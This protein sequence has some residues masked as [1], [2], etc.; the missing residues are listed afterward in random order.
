MKNLKKGRIPYMAK[1]VIEAF[2]ILAPILMISQRFVGV[3]LSQYSTGLAIN[4]LDTNCCVH[5]L[6]LFHSNR[7]ISNPVWESHNK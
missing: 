5:A 7:L 6:S 4:R 1:S 2:Y 3:R